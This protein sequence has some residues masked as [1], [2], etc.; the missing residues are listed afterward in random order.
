MFRDLARCTAR[1]KGERYEGAVIAAA[2]W[3]RKGNGQPLAE[4]AMPDIL[5][6]R[7]GMMTVRAA[8]DSGMLTIKMLLGRKPPKARTARTDEAL[9][10]EAT[11]EGVAAT[12]IRLRF[13]AEDVRSFVSDVNDMNALHEGGNPLVPGLLIME[14]VLRD[15]ALI[16]CPYL[17][18]K[19]TIP[20]F[21]SQ[22]VVVSL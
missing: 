13:T 8:D 16:A 7:H 11:A 4:N 6:D 17:L 20:V 12:S 9:R 19:F 15:R 22:E 18:M 14:R 21:V 1:L 2:E 10:L 5:L 3:S